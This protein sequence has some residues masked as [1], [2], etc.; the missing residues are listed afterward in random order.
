PTW[1]GRSLL[2]WPARPSCA[3]GWCA[4]YRGAEAK[5][6]DTRNSPTRRLLVTTPAT[7]T[8]CPDHAPAQT[9]RTAPIAPTLPITPTLPIAPTPPI[10]ATATGETR[11][12][13]VAPGAA[14]GG[15]FL[16][17]HC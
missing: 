4:C 12:L 17:A 13:R 10:A 11:C 9:E 5:N 16:W 3:S 7:F 1:P 6:R 8:P 14:P 15:P 2:A